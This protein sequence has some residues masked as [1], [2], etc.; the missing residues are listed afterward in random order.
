MGTG[1]SREI[2]AREFVERMTLPVWQA[3]AAVRWLEGRVRNR[4]KSAEATPEKAALTDGDCVSQEI[5]LV[6]LRAHFPWVSVFVEEDTPSAEAFA[7]NRSD[8]TV[9]IDPIDGTARYLRGDGPYAI[10]VGLER[11]GLVEAMLVAVPQFGVMVR[12]TSRSCA[13]SWPSAPWRSF[14]RT[15]RARCSRSPSC[16]PA[17][18]RARA[19][20]R[21][22]SG[23]SSARR[24]LRAF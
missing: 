2:R 5:L 7:A 11:D 20:A 12:A 22:T 9:V 4:P 17:S 16:S 8:E 21:S 6:A 3:T 24:D 10:L 23:R 13:S 18:E 14:P 19:R 15:S 1:A